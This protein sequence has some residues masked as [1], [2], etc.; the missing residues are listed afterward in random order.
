MLLL[1]FPHAKA[2]QRSAGEGSGSMQ[3]R[4]RHLH[5]YSASATTQAPTHLRAWHLSGAVT[6]PGPWK[7]VERRAKEIKEK[8][9]ANLC[10]GCHMHRRWW[11]AGPLHRSSS[12]CTD[13]QLC[14]TE[15]ASL[16]GRIK[17]LLPMVTFIP[18]D[19]NNK[20]N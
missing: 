11:S 16:L 6:Q 19:C 10:G 14:A 18:D 15:S 12:H 7:S 8:S 1:S 13:C 9:L 3:K 17:P 4:H 20:I 2:L 5:V